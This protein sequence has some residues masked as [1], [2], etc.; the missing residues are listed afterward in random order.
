MICSQALIASALATRAR[1]ELPLHLD[2]LPGA[3]R[4]QD[5]Q[6][7]LARHYAGSKR[8]LQPAA[9]LDLS[10]RTCNRA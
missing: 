3:P 10:R 6:D 9:R 7:A 1:A 5:L 8:L 4:A 2:L